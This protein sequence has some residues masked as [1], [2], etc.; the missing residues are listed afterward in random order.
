MACRK[1][2]VYFPREMIK[3]GA[4]TPAPRHL[5]LCL[6]GAEEKIRKEREGTRGARPGY[7]SFHSEL[8]QE[9]SDYLFREN[10]SLTMLRRLARIDS[11]PHSCRLPRVRKVNSSDR[12]MVF[13]SLLIGML[14]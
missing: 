5:S 4:R 12:H 8:P 14:T 11:R 13:E 7:F 10:D 6:H 3:E 1:V 9:H 2:L